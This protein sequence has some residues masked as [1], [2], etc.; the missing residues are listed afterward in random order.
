MA[1]DQ[2]KLAGGT[3]RLSNTGHGA[4]VTIRLPLHA[5]RPHLVLLA[6][7]DD[8]IR[9]HIR[10]MLTAQGHSVI[11]AASVAE[12]RGLTDLPGLTLILSDLQLG[13]GSGTELLGLGL[14][15]ILMTALPP[16]DARRSGLDCPVLTKPF[17]DI[18]LAA[19]MARTDD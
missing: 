17:D 15:G 4:Q 12:A 16:G 6:E 1:Y 2:I 19:A 11:E 10:E 14:P 3:L 5:A 13:D 8:T 18:E 7:D 9:T